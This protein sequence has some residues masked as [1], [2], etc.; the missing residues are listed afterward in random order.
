M[1]TLKYHGKRREGR[2]QVRGKRESGGVAGAVVTG[3]ESDGVAGAVVAGVEERW[4]RGR[5]AV[6]SSEISLPLSRRC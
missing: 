2:Y 6:E 4:G 5:A 3:R 1:N